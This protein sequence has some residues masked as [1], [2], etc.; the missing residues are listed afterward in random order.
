[1]NDYPKNWN[2]IALEIKCA[3]NFKCENCG[4][5]DDRETG[6]VLTVHHLD[7]N[8]ANCDPSNLVAL[9]QRCHLHFQNI[10]LLHQL[11]LF[12]PPTFLVRRFARIQGLK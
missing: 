9:C 11:W 5:G 6:H 12:D 3:A 10:D 8:K 1:V 2:E 7:R 4:H